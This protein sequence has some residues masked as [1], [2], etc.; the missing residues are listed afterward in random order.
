MATDAVKVNVIGMLPLKR[1]MELMK[2]PQSL[3]RRLLYRVA[4]KVISD[5]KQRVRQQRDLTGRPFETRKRKRKGGRKMLLKLGRE[6]KVVN[7][8][9]MEALI[10]FSR[11][12]SARI[13]AKHQYGHTETMTAAK[14]SRSGAG[15]H[16]DK[17]ATRKQAIALREAGFTIKKANGKGTK[18]PPLKWV[19]NNLTIG[20]A[21]FALKQLRIWSGEKIKS[22]WV[23]E[24]PAR[25]F[26]GATAAEISQHIDAI[27]NQMTQ[28]IKRRGYT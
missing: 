7:N 8:S 26:L 5:S 12:S 15:G 3:R 11:R 24:L 17:P 2:M 27:F 18:A 14:M 20:Q 16:Y 28:E 13:A 4:K 9:S 10:G 22:S 1:Q 23:T 6:L 25:S 21:G 19:Q